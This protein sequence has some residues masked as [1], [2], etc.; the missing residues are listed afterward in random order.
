MFGDDR[1]VRLR[2][3]FFPFTEPS[4]EVD[5]S[6]FNCTDG[7]C[8][9]AARCPLCKGS[10]WVEILGV[11]HGRPQRVRVRAR[12][13]Y[14]PERV[15]GFA[16]GM[17]IERIAMLKHGVPD[18]RLLLRQRRALPGAVRMRLPRRL[19]ARLLRPA[20]RRRAELADRFD[21]TGTEVERIEHHGVGALHPFVVGA[22]SR[23]TST[24]TPTG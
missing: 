14:D 4:A 18:L 15:Q 8:P 21:L 17:G 5:V 13:G 16:F 22:C 3:H 12:A 24:P 1:E 11:G 20:A 6:C 19:A 7:C 23:P 10:S 2:P 9:T